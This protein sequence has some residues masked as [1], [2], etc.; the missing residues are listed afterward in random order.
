MD[1]WVGWLVGWVVWLAVLDF[2][3]GFWFGWEKGY[4]L[5]SLT[6]DKLGSELLR[7][8]SSFFPFL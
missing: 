8:F 3:K 2:S 6:T 1:D 7:G 4:D 5:F